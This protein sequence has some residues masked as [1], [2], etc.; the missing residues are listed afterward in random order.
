MGF[1]PSCP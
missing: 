1:F